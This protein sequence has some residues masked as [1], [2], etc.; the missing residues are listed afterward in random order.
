M[1]EVIS[2]RSYLLRSFAAGAVATLASSAVVAMGPGTPAGA[3]AKSVA[4]QSVTNVVVHTS[5]EAVGVPARQTTL[6]RSTRSPS[7]QLTGSERAVIMMC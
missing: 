3:T 7:P 4:R 1:N 5:P 6:E 2:K